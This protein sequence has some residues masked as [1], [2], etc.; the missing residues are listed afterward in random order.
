MHIL[1]MH[2]CRIYMMRLYVMSNVGGICHIELWALPRE[3]LAIVKE[4]NRDFRQWHAPENRKMHFLMNV[5]SCQRNSCVKCL[6]YCQIKLKEYSEFKL[7]RRVVSP[8]KDNLDTFTAQLKNII[9][10]YSSLSKLQASHLCS[11]SAYLLLLIV[12]A[13]HRCGCASHRMHK[14]HASG[15][16]A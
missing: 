14:Q 1:H 12:R 6:V 15:A 11:F 2:L 10:E 3:T 16:A 5:L 13:S 8:Q 9:H 4:D 7:R